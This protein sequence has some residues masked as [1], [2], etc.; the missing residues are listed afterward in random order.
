VLRPVQ[1][2]PQPVLLERVLQRAWPVQQAWQQQ[3][4]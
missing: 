2:V 4:V 3:P 1:Q